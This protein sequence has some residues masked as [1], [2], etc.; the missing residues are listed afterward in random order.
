VNKHRAVAD[1]KFLE[2][3]MNVQ[4]YGSFDQVQLVRYLFVRKTVADQSRDLLFANGQRVIAAFPGCKFG[5]HVANPARPQRGHAIDE[6]FNFF[7]R[8]PWRFHKRVG[9]KRNR[10]TLQAITLIKAK[11]NGASK[12]T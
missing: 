7:G 10:T 11:R 12:V 5:L 4:L 3:V 9:G 1:T 8:V 2:N 6:L